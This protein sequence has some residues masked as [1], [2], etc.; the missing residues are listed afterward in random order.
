VDEIITSMCWGLYPALVPSPVL[1]IAQIRFKSRV[2][3]KLTFEFYNIYGAR[4]KSIWQGQAEAGRVLN[5]SFQITGLVP[6]VCL[7]RSIG[8]LVKFIHD[9]FWCN[10]MDSATKI[11]LVEW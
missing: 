8:K 5:I 3:G 4:I 2:Q 11:S 1:R 7:L 6:G 10:G 9:K